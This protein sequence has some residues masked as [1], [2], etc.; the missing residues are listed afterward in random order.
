MEENGQCSSHHIQWRINRNYILYKEHVS[1]N[2]FSDS[3]DKNASSSLSEY[4][5]SVFVYTGFGNSATTLALLCNSSCSGHVILA[6]IYLDG[7]FRRF[8]SSVEHK[9]NILRNSSGGGSYKYIYIYKHING[10][11]CFPTSIFQ[12]VFNRR[13]DSGFESIITN[14]RFLGELSLSKCC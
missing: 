8:L 4:C 13:R 11:E 9:D 5:S 10:C 12:N 3:S 2:L 1:I 14:F 6:Q 7:P